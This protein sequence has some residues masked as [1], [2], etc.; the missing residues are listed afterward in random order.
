M[1]RS[2]LALMPIDDNPHTAGKSPIKFYEAAAM[3]T[4]ALGLGRVYKR[5]IEHR[6]TGLCADDPEAFA[7]YAVEILSAPDLRS[8]LRTAAHKWLVDH[9][10][11]VNNLS[12][13]RESLTYTKPAC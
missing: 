11:L 10:L 9:G 13:W 8:K 5:V 2:D 4:A 7:R 3:G 12:S 6:R 1:G